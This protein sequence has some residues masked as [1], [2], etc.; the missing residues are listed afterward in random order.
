MI[1]YLL[2]VLIFYVEN[3]FKCNCNSKTIHNSFTD[4]AILLKSLINV[5][6]QQTA[7]Q[8]LTVNKSYSNKFHSPPC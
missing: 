5:N 2:P 1:F 6:S 7:H 3:Y 4:L 8:S